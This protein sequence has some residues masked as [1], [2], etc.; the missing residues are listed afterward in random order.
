MRSV[1]RVALG[2][3]VMCWVLYAQD[4]APTVDS[5]SKTSYCEVTP[6]SLGPPQV[7]RG[8]VVHRVKPKYPKEARRAKLEGTVRLRAT[9]AKDG[10]V[11]DL[12][13][14]S[15]DPILADA[16]LEAVKQWRYEPFLV[17]GAAAEVATEITVNFA[18]AGHG[19]VELS[20]PAVSPKSESA[21]TV[22]P[23]G[24]SPDV[25]YPIY[26]VAGDVK[27][28]KP[29][30]APNP[31]YT[32]SA[33]RAKK[34]GSIAL[35]IVITPEGDVQ[36]VE[37]CKHLEPSLDQRAVETVSRWKFDPATKEGKPVGVHVT[38]DVSFS[39]R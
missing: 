15:G 3:L 27:A 24:V 38:V 14:L 29:V 20:Q 4:A 36:N 39:T 12:S 7:Q 9:I 34:Q 26:A 23:T 28:P 10:T 35:A 37:V 13:V 1:G 30:Y 22:A 16:A 32:E 33:L 31:S 6:N 18:L 19:N 5:Q 21:S 25:P 11:R 8:R 17:N 2:A